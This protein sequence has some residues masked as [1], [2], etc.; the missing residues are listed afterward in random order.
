MHIKMTDSILLSL[1]LPQ[2]NKAILNEEVDEM[3]QLAATLG[4]KIQSSIIQNLQSVDSSTYFGKGKINTVVQQCNELGYRTLFINDE[5]QPGHFKRIQKIAGENLLII[6]RTKLILDIFND[7]AKTVEA[8]KQ[9]ELAALEYMMPRLVGQWT[10]L[11]RQMGGIGARGGPGEKQIEIDRRLVRKDINKLKKDLKGIETQRITQRKSRSG[12]FKVSLAGYTNAGKSSLLKTLTGY[13]AYI[14]NQLFATLDT[15][16]KKIKLDN[17]LDIL[18]SD[19]VGFLRNLPHDLI[20]SFRSTLGE[21]EDSD[22]IIKLIDIN[23]NDI[24]GHIDTIDE[25][26]KYLNCDKKD[27]IIVFNKIDLVKDTTIYDRLINRYP[28]CIFISSL[29]ELRINNLL[30]IIKDYSTKDLS[31]FELQIP[32]S[33]S[34]LINEIYKKA[35]V[36][37]RINEYEYIYIKMLC[38]EKVFRKISKEIDN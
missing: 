31:S 37:E 12:I 8:K 20:A 11:E 10:H 17:N 9:I 27:Y 21:I 7:H 14:K 2:T 36:S 38:T 18:I 4:Y 6:D 29:K 23:S 24:S 19:T 32:H 30:E 22:L 16:T 35:I 3:K 25:N 15:T 26:L 28:G 13:K 33:K 5:L 34:H 1:S